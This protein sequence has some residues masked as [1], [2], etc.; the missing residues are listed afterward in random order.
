LEVTTVI[1]GVR[2]KKLAAIADERGRVMEVLRSDDDLFIRFGQV[3]I[4]T[5]YPGVV[6]AWH[7]HKKQYDSFA[8]ISG[9]MKVVLYDGRDASATQGEVNEFFIGVH[10]PMLVQ[11]PPG[12]MHGFKCISDDEAIMLNC[13]T[14]V[15][16][17]EAPDELRAPAHSPEVPYDWG[18]KD[19]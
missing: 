12:V 5:A 10:N 6:K 19:G 15:Y 13:P 14:E 11:V 7:Y 1:E 9:M 3:Y 4:T 17:H 8:C 16:S 18:R 2:T